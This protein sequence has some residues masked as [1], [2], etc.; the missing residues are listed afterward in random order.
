MLWLLLQSRSLTDGC[1]FAISVFP[2]TLCVPLQAEE[3]AARLASM[4]AWRRDMMK[5][6]M[7][8]E[9][10]ITKLNCSNCFCF[11]IGKPLNSV[12]T[13]VLR[14]VRNVMLPFKIFTPFLFFAYV[15]LM[16][17]GTKKVRN[18]CNFTYF[19]KCCT[20][21]KSW[22]RIW[23]CLICFQVLDLTCLQFQSTNQT[24]VKT[25]A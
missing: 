9:R 8:E 24:C 6:K 5:K 15:L 12:L 19:F 4:P 3:E 7:E 2:L 14:V 18:H 16:W 11:V 10:W 17:K 25:N 22:I 1:G 20:V 23:V 21:Q 13:V